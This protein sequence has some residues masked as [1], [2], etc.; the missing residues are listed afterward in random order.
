MCVCADSSLEE[1]LLSAFCGSANI[2]TITVMM[3]LFLHSLTLREFATLPG[4]PRGVL[5]KIILLDAAEPTLQLILS[6]LKSQDWRLPRV[7]PI[8]LDL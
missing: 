5:P 6:D 4:R 3:I 1:G 7:G 8:H 2:W